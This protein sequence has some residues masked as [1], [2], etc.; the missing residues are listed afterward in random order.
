MKRVILFCMCMLCLSACS[1]AAD[2]ADIRDASTATGSAVSGSGAVS[3]QSVTQKDKTEQQKVSI[4]TD[5]TG[6][7]RELK[8]G[9]VNTKD[10]GVYF[11]D[12]Y[13]VTDY[14]QVIDGH[15]YYLRYEGAKD[16]D[17][18][19]YRDRGEKV[20]GFNLFE[21][22]TFYDYTYYDIMGFA[23]YGENFYIIYENGEEE[24]DDDLEQVLFDADLH[25]LN[26]LKLAR[27]D[28][29]KGKVEDIY[30]ITSSFLPDDGN[31]VFCN[32]YKDGF[33]FD[34]RS[35][36][37]M[38]KSSAGN[39]VKFTPAKGNSNTES[40]PMSS[41]AAKAKPYLTYIDGKVY[42][43]VAEG[44]KVTL[45]SSDL[46]SGEEKE[47]FQYEREQAY[48]TDVV[49]LAMDEDY[50][51]CQDYL[52]P[53]SGGRM[54]RVLQNA[55][56]ES[57]TM[58]K[59]PNKNYSVPY[60]TYNQ[61]YIFYIDKKDKVHRIDKATKKDII[62]SDQKA[63]GVDCTEDNVYIRVH[64]KAWYG[65]SMWEE[66]EDDDEGWVSPNFYSNHIYCMDLNGKN[67][68][69]IWKGSWDYD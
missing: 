42:Y 69:Q 41:N 22:E 11:S 56:M 55:K 17:Y 49:H 64:A 37:D 8:L 6:K 65:K 28:L 16:G 59:I 66:F 58:E 45:Y 33:Y 38:K 13:W 48:G 18:I 20:G 47:I 31:L 2:N 4:V 29:E 3:G 67:V 14:S 26:P 44:K 62:I 51:Y 24:M 39:S 10:T 40:I 34:E 5:E 52:I 61:K 50:I 30:D 32:I 36:Q 63:I 53:R 12:A 57:G 1:S 43:G 27:V 7:K 35:V 23:K 15:Y 46:E 54:I 68:K 9:D 60:Y 25:Y 21:Y 19:I